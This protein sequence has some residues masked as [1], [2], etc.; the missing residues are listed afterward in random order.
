MVQIGVLGV[1]A[2]ATAGPEGA[3]DVPKVVTVWPVR[4]SSRRDRWIELASLASYCA[5]TG[6]RGWQ[7][8]V[9]REV[10]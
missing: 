8:S 6:R 7:S 9:H 5:T 4:V 1:A 10:D 3:S 2:I